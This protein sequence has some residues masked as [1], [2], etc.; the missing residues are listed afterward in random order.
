MTSVLVVGAGVIGLTSALELLNAGYKVTIIA[1]HFN[2]APKTY[3]TSEVAGALW[4]WPPAVCGRH[5]NESSLKSSKRWCMVSYWKFIQL[6]SEERGTGIYPRKAVFYQRQKVEENADEHCKM[7]EL[8]F[9]PGFCHDSQLIDEFNVNRNY[10]VKDAYSH[11]SPV[12]DTTQMMKWLYKQCKDHGATFFKRRVNGSLLDQVDTLLVEYDVDFIVNCAGLGARETADDKGVYPLRGMLL[13]VANDGSKMPKLNSAL[14]MPLN[15]E[16]MAKDQRIVF[17]L[18]RGE[19]DLLIGGLVE[20]GQ[21]ETEGITFNHPQIQRML[22]NCQDFFPALKA[23]QESDVKEIIVGLR[24]FREN[25]IRVEMEPK[26]RKIIH[27]YGHGGSG[28]SLSWGC[29]AD[30]TNLIQHEVQSKLWSS[31]MMLFSKL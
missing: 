21:S 11:I 14:V 4:E 7:Q 9:L 5:T 28:W 2:E 20:A 31:R 8:S 29:A 3:M 12:V 18:P 24:P 16:F 10:G 27:N 26:C 25:N 15:E 6:A 23:Y 22:K 1:D 13:K 17:I 19:N 30:V